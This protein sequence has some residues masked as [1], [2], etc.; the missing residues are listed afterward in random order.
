MRSH[1]TKFRRH[2]YRLSTASCSGQR[3]IEIGGGCIPRGRAENAL[4][5]LSSSRQRERTLVMRSYSG[6][7]EVLG[8]NIAGL[9]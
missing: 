6:D 2:Y 9:W 7:F 8:G 4:P 1:L 5:L 3:T